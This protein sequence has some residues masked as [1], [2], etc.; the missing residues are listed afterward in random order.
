[1]KDDGDDDD[2]VFTVLT[3]AN[4]GEQENYERHALAGARKKRARIY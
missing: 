3:T 2:G 4:D 1:M